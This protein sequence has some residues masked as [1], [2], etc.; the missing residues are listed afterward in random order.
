MIRRIVALALA[1]FCLAA[2]GET[3][4]A[5]FLP[6]LFGAAKP[7][8]SLVFDYQ[9]WRVDASGAAKAQRP[10]KTV[11]AIRAQIDLVQRAGLPQ[12]VLQV[13]RA[14]PVTAAT[15]LSPDPNGYVRGRGVTLHV[16]DLDD[17]RPVLL[18]LLLYAYEDQ[19]LPGGGANPDVA[20]FRQAAAAEHVWPKTA[21]M[22]R[23]DADYF[24]MTASAYL[25]GAITRE[26]YTR[27]NL[28]RTQPDAY[29]WLARLFDGG[30][31]RVS[32]RALS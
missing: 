12:A 24:A 4:A 23:S 31:A 17:K 5:P 21:A 8:P 11:K 16:K 25:V 29:Q 6:P 1:A 22:L 20:R 30:R 14:V 10:A 19:G 7:Q 32:A 15:G 9:G 3:W 13:M 27:A 2:S 18:R 26:P 28:R